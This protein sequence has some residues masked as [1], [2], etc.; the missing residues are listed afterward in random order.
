MAQR[1]ADLVPAG[2]NVDRTAAEADRVVIWVRAKAHDCACPDCGER[3]RRVRSRYWRR[4]TD[5]PLGGR[6]VELRVMVSALSVRRC[7]LSA[8]DLRRAVCGRR[9]G[10]ARPANRTAGP[11]RAS[12]RP[13]LGRTPRRRLRCTADD[14]REQRHVVA[15]RS[16][17]SPAAGRSASR[18]RHRRLRVAAES[19]LRHDRLRPRA[20]PDGRASG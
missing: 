4:P 11:H 17:T 3:S 5:L 10:A 6:R 8:P 18:D 13:C 20:P 12:S 2:F 15:R 16:T 9:P 14:P 7:P 19:S 1:V